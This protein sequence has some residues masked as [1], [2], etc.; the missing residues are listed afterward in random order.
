MRIDAA[1]RACR[2]GPRIAARGVLKRGKESAPVERI[3]GFRATMTGSK[4][5]SVDWLRTMPRVEV[6]TKPRLRPAR[7]RAN[8]QTLHFTPQ[9]L[10]ARHR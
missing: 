9:F 4:P 3:T 7:D 5:R 6:G 2:L 8:I 1:V 10:D